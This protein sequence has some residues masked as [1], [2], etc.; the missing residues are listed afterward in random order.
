MDIR[1]LKAG[2]IVKC[3][4]NYLDISY[5]EKYG[6]IKLL[7]LRKNLGMNC[8][9][10]FKLSPRLQPEKKGPI[11]LKTAVTSA[12]PAYWCALRKT[13]GFAQ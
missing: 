13:W 1:D 7:S 3:K 8:R 6:V 10:T 9:S 4:L 5:P 11:A 12:S 2:F